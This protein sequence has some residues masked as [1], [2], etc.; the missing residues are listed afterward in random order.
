MNEGSEVVSTGY[1]P[2]ISTIGLFK[3]TCRTIVDFILYLKAISYYLILSF[4]VPYCT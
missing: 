2:Q 3:K 4:K 1:I